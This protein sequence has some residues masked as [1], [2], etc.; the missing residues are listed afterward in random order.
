MSPFTKKNITKIHNISN[1]FE[2]KNNRYKEI[3]TR[4][5]NHYKIS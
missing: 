3:I 4:D 2:P 5:N 1:F